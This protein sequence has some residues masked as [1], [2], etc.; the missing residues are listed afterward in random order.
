MSEGDIIIMHPGA[1]HN[2]YEDKE[3]I[4]C[5]FLIDK[6]WLNSEL[7]A[8]S[9]GE[10]ALIDF[11][12][13]SETDNF[14][15]YVVCPIDNNKDIIVNRAKNVITSSKETSPWKYILTETALLELLA[16]ISDVCDGVYLS[17]SRGESSQIMIDML[18]F[19]TEN[20][21]TVDLET[22]ADRYYYSKTHICRLFL[23]NTGKS[24]TNFLI[25]IKIGKACSMLETTDMTVG[26]ISEFLGYES[27]EYFYRL[28]KRKKGVTPKEYRKRIR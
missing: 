13:A 14:Y 10:G 19:V 3:S 27:V 25:D 16:S 22:V 20:C 23:Q 9:G 2:L 6:K 7:G 4:V 18:E 28:F 15:K 17:K 26:E 24:F 8:L 11:F 21:T 5:N 12:K 1:Y